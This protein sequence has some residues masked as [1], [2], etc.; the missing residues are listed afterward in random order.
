MKKHK[1]LKTQ[2]KNNM[3]GKKQYKISAREKP[4]NP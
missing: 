2:N 3:A 1:I 4:P